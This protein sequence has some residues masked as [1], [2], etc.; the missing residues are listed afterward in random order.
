VRLPRIPEGLVE[1][2][3]IAPEVAASR[4][5]HIL[6]IEDNTDFRE[7]LRLLL[8]SWGHRVEEASNGA[9]GLE[10]VRRERPE[11]VLIDLGL[12]GVDGYGV[13]RALRSAPEGEALLL[14]AITGYGRPSDR[15]QTKEAGFDAH[16]TKPVSPPE[17]AA[18]LLSKGA[19]AAG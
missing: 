17:L 6:I 5:R 15:R 1:V 16:L 9:K 7:G 4:A 12:P 13:A 2:E 10:I 8:E 11:I 18:I 19:G 3:P 14:V